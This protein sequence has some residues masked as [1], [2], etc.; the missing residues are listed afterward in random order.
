METLKTR[1]RG[2]G[3][4]RGERLGLELDV[5]GSYSKFEREADWAFFYSNCANL[6][7]Y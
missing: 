5:I 2:G 3:D 6:G 4:G 7:P 1:G